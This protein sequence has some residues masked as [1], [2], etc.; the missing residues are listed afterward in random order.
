MGHVFAAASAVGGVGTPVIS[1]IEGDRRM[2]LHNMSGSLDE[3]IF[4]NIGVNEELPLSGMEI[5][6]HEDLWLWL[7]NMCTTIGVEN[8]YREEPNIPE[9]NLMI[10]DQSIDNQATEYHFMMVKSL[11]HKY[12]NG[13]NNPR[14]VVAVDILWP[15]FF[16][17]QL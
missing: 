7:N 16:E 10:F 11:E 2:P 14:G 8:T 12:P 1:T 9:Y 5:E 4:E 6:N 13:S 3:K 15:W 17:H